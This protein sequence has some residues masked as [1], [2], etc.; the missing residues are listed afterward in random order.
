VPTAA[1]AAQ[2]EK[3]PEPR[4]EP[5]AP[6]VFWQDGRTIVRPNTRMLVPLDALRITFQDG[7]E[8]EHMLLKL[9]ICWARRSG[10]QARLFGIN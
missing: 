7:E 10:L 4:T 3:K 5:E 8:W 6:E 1:P 9:R 2:P